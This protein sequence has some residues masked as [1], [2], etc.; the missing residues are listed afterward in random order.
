MW[1]AVKAT[2]RPVYPRDIPGTHCIRGWVGLTAGTENLAL[3]GFDP[4]T[5]QHVANSYTD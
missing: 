5:V 4:R 2:P 3:T 1:W